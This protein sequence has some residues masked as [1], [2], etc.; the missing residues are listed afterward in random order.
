MT[1]LETIRSNQEFKNASAKYIQDLPQGNVDPAIVESWREVINS[2]FDS[3]NQNNKDINLYPN[4][5][6][7][8]VGGG[9]IRVM[10]VESTASGAEYPVRA[11]RCDLF[12]ELIHTDGL[13]PVYTR[14]GIA[15]A[16]TNDDIVAF[17]WRY[18]T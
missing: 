3:I 2:T 14:E 11:Q 10:F 7:S 17:A 12:G 5:V 1:N 15:L 6:Y 16:D 9:Y 8:T 13:Q 4:F 18:G